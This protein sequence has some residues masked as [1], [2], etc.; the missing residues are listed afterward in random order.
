[1][2]DVGFD[3]NRVQSTR[4]SERFSLFFDR[5]FYPHISVYGQW[6]QST[7][8]NHVLHRWVWQKKTKNETRTQKNYWLCFAIMFFLL[9]HYYCCWVK[10]QIK[11]AD[12]IELSCWMRKQQ[13]GYA[14][15][16]KLF[17]LKS[18]S[19]LIVF[20]L[21]F[22]LFFK[23]TWTPGYGRI[24]ACFDQDDSNWLTFVKDIFLTFSN[25]LTT[26]SRYDRISIKSWWT[27]NLSHL[28]YLI[29]SKTKSKVS[30]ENCISCIRALNFLR[31]ICWVG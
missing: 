13:I 11:I 6:L 9:F 25:S 12:H 24:S 17:K 4:R 10:Y 5:Q 18:F 29:R 2:D 26:K 19:T 8:K 21:I 22:F 23:L 27:A 1:M 3:L 16:R 15:L 30:T 28:P 20:L 7:E 14:M 31:M